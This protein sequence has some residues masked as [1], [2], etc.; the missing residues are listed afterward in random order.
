MELAVTQIPAKDKE[1]LVWKFCNLKVTVIPI[2]IDKLGTVTKEL[3]QGSVN[4]EIRG[5]VES[6]Q[7]Q[8]YWDWP[9][10]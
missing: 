1:M 5:R 2:G 7:I 4:L 3:V 10:Y 9:E 6:I 8:N